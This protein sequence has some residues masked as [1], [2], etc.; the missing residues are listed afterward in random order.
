MY[1]TRKYEQKK[2]V[3]LRSHVIDIF[4]NNIF[5]EVPTKFIQDSEHAQKK[6]IVKK[7]H[8]IDIYR[9]GI[10]IEELTLQIFNKV[11]T[12]SGHVYFF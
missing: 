8:I 6:V 3:V 11:K 1:K 9:N 7:F 2:V 4:R 5:I 12:C 10:I